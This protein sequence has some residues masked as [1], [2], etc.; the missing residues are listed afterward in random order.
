MRRPAP[1]ILIFIRDFKEIYDI[2]LDTA[3]GR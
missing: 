1:F 3:G 2:Q